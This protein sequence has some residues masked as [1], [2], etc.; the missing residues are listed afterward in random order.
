M[1]NRKTLVSVHGYAGDQQQVWDLLPVFEHH[2]CPVIILSPEDSH[3]ENVKGHICRFAGKRAYVGQDSWDR[4]HLQLKVLLEYDFDWYLLNDS[5]SFIISPQIPDYLFES[6]D[7]VWSNEVKDFRVPGTTSH[8]VDWPMDY[9]AGY[10]LIA[11]Q[12]PYFLSRV[13]LEKLVVAS[14]GLVACPTTPFIDW[15]FLPACKKAGLVHAPFR[16]GASCETITQ[17]GVSAM[18]N[19]VSNEKAVC[20]HSIKSLEIRKMLVQAYK[21]TL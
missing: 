3:I 6:K 4:Q 14:E 9:H 16:N 2:R 8:G 19:A 5:D 17:N 10:S 18:A 11:M 1:N 15:W 7:V 13:T 12:P 21:K 20:L